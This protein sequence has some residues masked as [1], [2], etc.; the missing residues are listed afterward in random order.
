M[1]A[2]SSFLDAPARKADLAATPAAPAMPAAHVDLWERCTVALSADALAALARLPQEIRAAATEQA[3]EALRMEFIRECDRLIALGTAKEQLRPQRIIEAANLAVYSEV[4]HT[5]FRPWHACDAAALAKAKSLIETSG[6]RGLQDHFKSLAMPALFVAGKSSDDRDSYLQACAAL[7]KRIRPARLVF[8][9]EFVEWFPERDFVQACATVG[10]PCGHV[11]I[12]ERAARE[13]HSLMHPMHHP[14][15][16][17]TSGM[18]LDAAA[19][20]QRGA[21]RPHVEAPGQTKVASEAPAANDPAGA[22]SETTLNRI[23]QLR[24]RQAAARRPR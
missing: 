19:S 6:F 8:D 23:A 18:S 10:I 9:A 5:A 3:Q 21:A 1:Q 2:Q 14:I 7:V 15:M 17:D 12:V 4:S 11:G 24:S 20:T 16:V 13:S 22:P